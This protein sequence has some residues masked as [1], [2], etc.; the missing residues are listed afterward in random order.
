MKKLLLFLSMMCLLASLTTPAYAYL[1]PGTGSVMVQGLL[2]GFAGVLAILKL[3]WQRVKNFLRQLFG[4]ATHAENTDK[5]D[6]SAS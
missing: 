4:K 5:N 1:D 2:A 3:Y 6:N